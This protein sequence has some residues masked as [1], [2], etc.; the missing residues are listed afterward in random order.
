MKRCSKKVCCKQ[1]SYGHAEGH[2]GTGA[3]L[4]KKTNTDHAKQSYVADIK[5]KMF[6]T[7]CFVVFIFYWL[8]L[9]IKMSS[10]TN[11]E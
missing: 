3:P 4:Y 9:L 10:S 6:L 2:H 11:V 7:F 5:N 8:F 1:C